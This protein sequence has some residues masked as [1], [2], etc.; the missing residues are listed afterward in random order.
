MTLF[1]FG[2][3][4]IAALLHVAWNLL[5]KRAG[6]KLIVLWLGFAMG[7]VCF[8]P[9]MAIHLPIPVK[10]WPYAFASAICESGYMITLASAYKRD[11]FSLVYPIARGSAPALLAVWSI[12]FL[13][14]TP[15]R[16]GLLGLAILTIG[17]MIVGSSQWW[18]SRKKGRSS[19]TGLGQASMV[20]VIISFYSVIDGGAV[21]WMDAL[22]YTILTSFM[23]ALLAAPLILIRFGWPV[24]QQEF[25]QNW[26]PSAA[27]GLLMISAYALVLVVYSFS[28]VSYA[29][30]IREISIVFGAL[31]GWL[32]LKEKLGLIR[33]AGAL[34][35]FCGILIILVAG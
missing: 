6:G 22:S 16:T 10:I 7:S 23:T 11:D 25:R 14:E 13:K 2:L 26:R 28:P 3:L 4:I 32:W 1:A 9:L 24:I 30:A 34:V 33:V 29:G 31:A 5:L 21:K 27:I 15:S 18:E 20:A 17:L 19:L 35:I 12:L 8:L